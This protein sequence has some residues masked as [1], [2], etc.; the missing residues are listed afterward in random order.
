MRA[1]LIPLSLGT[2][3]Q[4]AAQTIQLS[5][6]H[7]ACGNGNGAVSA[8][9]ADGVPPFTAVWSTGLTSSGDTLD[10]QINGLFAGFYSLTVT[11]DLGNSVTETAEVLNLPYLQVNWPPTFDW[12]ACDGGCASILS[13]GVPYGAGTAGP[14]YSVTGLAP[15]TW[16]LSANWL[17]M[18]SLCANQT[19]NVVL[20]D[21]LGCTAE[22]QIVVADEPSPNLLLSSVTGACAGAE[23][24]SAT[25]QFDMQVQ[26]NVASASGPTN[27][28]SISYPLPG[29]VQIDGIPAGNYELYAVPVPNPTCFDTIPFAVPVLPAG[30]GTVSG[31]AFADLD[32][33]CTQDS[34]EPGLPHRMISFSPAASNAITNAQGQ[35]TRGMPLGNYD[36]DINAPGFDP[37]C[38][39]SLPAPFTL[40]AITPDATLDLAMSTALLPDAATVLGV[41]CHSPGYL[42]L[43]FADVMNN[44]PFTLTNLTLQVDFS[45]VLTYAG[46]DSV[47]DAQ[48]ANWVSWSIPSLPPF[49]TLQ[50][51]FSVQVPPDPL[52]IGMALWAQST[53]TSVPADSDPANNT[54]SLNGIVVGP[55]D[56]ND[57]LARTSSSGNDGYYML[58]LDEHID[59]TIRFQNTGNAPAQH[60]FL[61]DT[62]GPELDL[63]SF[64]FLG[65]SHPESISLLP[66]R[67]L[68]FDFFGIQLPDSAMDPIGSHGFAR[69]RLKPTD[70]MPGDTLRNTADIYFDFN[71]PI[72]T[73]T[74]MLHVDVAWSISTHDLA[75]ITVV[76]NPALDVVVIGNLPHGTNELIWIDMC[77]RVALRS[78]VQGPEA[79]VNASALDRGAY[80][81]QL[82]TGE[83]RA[84]VGRC[85]LH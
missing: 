23:N 78:M 75:G 2:C 70:P 12:V 66:D 43:Y 68:R 73:N 42:A 45:P 33:D 57:K 7:D 17:T 31:T 63:A 56:P 51:A 15:G 55:Y 20:S 38:P 6:T 52:L 22:T 14:P 60:V 19:Y 1:I 58:P 18:A 79:R 3:L 39:A 10:L 65:A 21:A 49:T 41:T 82:N 32:G 4:A 76:P 47:P 85:V 48:G 5:V 13:F 50:Y 11:D 16:S 29:Q 83:S 69:F 46:S 44:G 36:A 80:I 26:V 61:I 28:I 59:Y 35:Y 37:N 81:L 24:G 27:T 64:E 9:I 30:C 25:F 77:G 72:R 8:W 34:G 84:Q 62:I 53:I 67:V 74:A 71:P 40:T 54:Y